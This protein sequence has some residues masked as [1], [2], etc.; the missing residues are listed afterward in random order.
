MSYE[1]LSKKEGLEK[2]TTLSQDSLP[3]DCTD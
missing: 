2:E 3:C 1:F